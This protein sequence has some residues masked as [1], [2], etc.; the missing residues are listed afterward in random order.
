[1]LNR[2]K[3]GNV[4]LIK[5]RIR[6]PLRPDQIPGYVGPT[7]GTILA[8]AVKNRRVAMETER[9]NNNKSDTDD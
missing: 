1:L 6:P 8:Q 9:I 5:P 4:Q 3:E 7:I 2:I